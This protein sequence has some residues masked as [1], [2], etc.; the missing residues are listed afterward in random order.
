ME[1]IMFDE[2]KRLPND[3]LSLTR[4]VPVGGWE[5][6]VTVGFYPDTGNIAEVFVKVGKMGSVISGLLDSWC[7]TL[8]VLLQTGYGW[9]NIKGK[10]YGSQFE[11][12]DD[13]FPSVVHAIAATIDDLFQEFKKESTRGK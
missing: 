5:L 4:K 11:P 10:Y 13:N 7:K 2:R 8:S 3:R 12:H 1:E 6:Y 9:D